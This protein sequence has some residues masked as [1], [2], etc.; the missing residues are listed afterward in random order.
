METPRLKV[1][2]AWCEPNPHNDTVIS[3]KSPNASLLSLV[4]LAAAT[5]LLAG[6]GAV[7]AC[8][9]NAEQT[10]L[11]FL[12]LPWIATAFQVLVFS[13]GAEMMGKRLKTW[14]AGLEIAVKGVLS[15]AFCSAYVYGNRTDKD[16]YPFWTLFVGL[17][18]VVLVAMLPVRSFKLLWKRGIVAFTLSIPLLQLYYSVTYGTVIA[19]LP[20]SEMYTVWICYSYPVVIGL[21]KVI[22]QSEG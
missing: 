8:Y 20:W 1:S 13:C 11:H 18:L 17:E 15:G 9:D 6:G 4:P 16:D 2:N 14:E 10:Y 7:M 22:M 3:V 19:G 5:L 12:K 21:I